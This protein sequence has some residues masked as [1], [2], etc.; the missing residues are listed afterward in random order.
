MVLFSLLPIGIMQAIA[1]MDHGLWYARS[2][3]FL[4]QPYLQTLRWLRAIGDTVFAAG[5]ASLVYFVIGLRFGWSIEKQPKLL[6][7]E[8]GAGRRVPAH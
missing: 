5:V 4:Q 7:E 3:E 6:P 8:V 2:A 1:S